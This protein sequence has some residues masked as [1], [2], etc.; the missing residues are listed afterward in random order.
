MTSQLRDSGLSLPPLKNGDRLS[1]AEFERRY[2]AMPN[3]KKA[4]LIEGVVYMPAAALRFQSH[5]QPHAALMT[6]LGFYEAMTPNTAMGDNTTVR[7]DPANAPQPDAILLINSSAGGRTRL[8]QNDYVEGAP[9]LVAE[10]SA[11]TT[12][13]LGDKKRVYCRNGVQEYIVWRVLEQKLDWFI[14]QD[15]KYVALQPDEDGVLRSLIFP[16]LW[17][18]VSDLLAGNMPQ[19]L[20]VLQQGLAETEHQDFVQ[21]L[22]RKA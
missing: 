6:W 1:W 17:L 7:L 21:K 13:D 2:E 15:G 20:E 3:L 9:E 10:V 16:G 18:A 14:W 12:L 11:S 5:A 22:A 8:S 19:V 4:E